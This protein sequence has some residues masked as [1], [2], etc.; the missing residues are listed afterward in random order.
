MNKMEKE[1]LYQIEIDPERPLIQH[2]GKLVSLKEY[3]L[4]AI[5]EEFTMKR[6]IKG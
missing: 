2:N 6:M 4:I 5:N 1:P 3:I